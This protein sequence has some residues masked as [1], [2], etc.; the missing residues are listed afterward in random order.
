MS[1]DTLYTVFDL[2]VHR[3]CGLDVNADRSVHVY[4]TLFER[5]IELFVSILAYYIRTVN[6][7]LLDYKLQT[8]LYEVKNSLLSLLLLLLL[9]LLELIIIIIIIIIIVI[10]LCWFTY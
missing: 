1:R 5:I 8:G 6:Y 3:H 4:K 7:Y 2:S 9:L 10:Y